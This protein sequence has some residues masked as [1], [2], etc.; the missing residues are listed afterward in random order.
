VV[1]ITATV[2]ATA[3]SDLISMSQTSSIPANV[4]DTALPSGM[5]RM[6]SGS[7][8]TKKL[9]TGADA[10]WDAALGWAR[11]LW[12]RRHLA[13]RRAERILSLESTVK[14]LSQAH[15][16]QR[17]EQL[18]AVFRRGRETAEQIDHAFALVRE[19]AR[20]ELGLLAH[21]E[22]VAAAVAMEQGTIVELATGE[23]KTLAATLPATLAGWRGR[24]CHVITVND[25]LARRDAEWMSGIYRCCGLTVRHVDQEMTPPDRRAAYEADITYCTNKEVAA[26]YLRDRLVLGSTR[27]LPA[28]LLDKLTDP[29]GLAAA[30]RLVLRGLATAIIDEADSILVDE[31]VTPLIISGQG[32]NREQVETFQQAAGLAGQLSEGEHYRVDHRYREVTLTRAGRAALDEAAESLG[33]IWRGQRR[34]DELVIQALTAHHLYRRGEQYI[35]QDDKVVIVDEFTGR[36]MPDRTWRDGLHQAVE[37][38]EQLDVNPPKDTLARVSFQRFFRLYAKLSGMTGTA[39][40]A[41][42]ELWQIYHRPVVR[43]PTH[44]P[45]IRRQHPD[46]VFT[47]A[48]AKWQALIEHVERV[49]RSSQP[50]LIGT[51]SVAA[52]EHLS[53]LL[54]ERGLEHEVLNA[55]KHA[56]E[57]QIVA[58]AGQLGRITVATNMAGRGTD[59]KPGRGVIESGGLH[60]IATERHE[61]GRV[62]RQL[63]GRT[64]R[65]GDPGSAIAFVSLEDEL[66]VRHGG[67]ARRWGWVP[68][69]WIFRYAQHRSQRQAL[70]QRK[71]VLRTDHW[72]DEHLGFAGVEG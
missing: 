40:E 24:G 18:R 57:A 45:C 15:L 5:W 39:W 65:Q 35:V 53:R 27:R 29:T 69:R 2:A 4:A 44:R 3:F 67:W 37:A 68:G 36:L 72:L 50:I 38:K 71:A 62:D 34:R 41:R 31:A 63:F 42:H 6:L 55:V 17:A 13:L 19:V 64:G 51:R 25:Y 60:V 61:A 22:Q 58:G 59:I 66:V 46:R 7:S 1:A 26:D 12:P 49:H 21:R 52:S 43:I 33:G 14:D 16:R 47:T 8:T 32:A 48:E 56:E 20:R 70:Q 28:V 30:D 23:G 11:A 10:A 9:P 54:Q